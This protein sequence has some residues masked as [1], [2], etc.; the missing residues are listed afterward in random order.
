MGIISGRYSEAFLG[1]LRL[2]L[3]EIDRKTR[4]LLTTR[5][6]FQPKSNVN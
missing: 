2:Q 5:N 4:K 6:G 1:W 3:E